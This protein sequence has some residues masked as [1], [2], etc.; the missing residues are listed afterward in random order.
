MLP[1]DPSEH[2]VKSASSLLAG[3]G[4][5]E[6][7]SLYSAELDGKHRST[8]LSAISSCLDELATTEEE[9]V[10]DEV[11]EEEVVEEE[12][13]SPV[14]VDHDTF[15]RMRGVERRMWRYVGDGKY[16]KLG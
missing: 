2:S 14:F 12:V 16:E 7:L 13:P 10:G 15:M 3:L 9:A 6:L 11:V 5:S 8:L 1:F 4:K